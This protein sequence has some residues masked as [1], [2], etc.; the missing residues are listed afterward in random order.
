MGLKRAPVLMTER[1]TTR[2]KRMCWINELRG[3]EKLKKKKKVTRREECIMIL[4][5]RTN[6]TGSSTWAFSWW[7]WL[8][9]IHRAQGQFL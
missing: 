9:M 2:Q 7:P 3:Q 1:A 6:Y 5:V 8:E 4:V